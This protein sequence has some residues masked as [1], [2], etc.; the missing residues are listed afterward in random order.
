MWPFNASSTDLRATM[1]D[2]SN[3][4]GL[5]GQARTELERRAST[6]FVATKR[7]RLAQR[8]QEADPMFPVEPLVSGAPGDR[9]A[10]V[11]KRII[12]A[13]SGFVTGGPAGAA[14]G[15]IRGGRPPGPGSVATSGGFGVPRSLDD[16][17]PPGQRRSGTD[18][19]TAGFK[20]ALQRTIPFGA[21]GTISDVTGEAVMGAFNVPATVPA[22]V[23]S[24][25]RHDGVVSPILR[26]PRGQ[27]L[28]TDNLCYAKGI[29][30]LAAFRKWKPAAKG[31]LPRRDVACL[32]RAIAIKKSK[33]NRA[34]LR[35]LGLG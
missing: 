20:G 30:G 16:G 12:G 11:H 1:N 24:I 32:R 6:E 13:V 9:R 26:C 31:F 15:F 25:E 7:Q 10:F 18:C 21:T 23:G 28:A 35:E 29:K 2:L 8:A 27:V 4:P 5:R 3:S 33:T 34:M 19:V 17:C 14:A 22:Q